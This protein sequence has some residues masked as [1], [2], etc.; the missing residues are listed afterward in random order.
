M[1]R[2]KQLLTALITASV[3]TLAATSAMADGAKIFR[4]QT[5][6]ERG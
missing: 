6:E 3:I 2:A 5:L 4:G 1:K